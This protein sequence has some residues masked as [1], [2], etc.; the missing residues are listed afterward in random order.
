MDGGMDM[1]DMEVEIFIQIE[2]FKR[3]NTV[4]LDFKNIFGHCHFGS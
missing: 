2:M 3:W 1:K 4:K